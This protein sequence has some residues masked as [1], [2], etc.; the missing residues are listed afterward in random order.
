MLPFRKSTREF[1]FFVGNFEQPLPL[2]QN[3]DRR[4]TLGKRASEDLQ[5]FIFRRRIFLGKTFCKPFSESMIFSKK[6]AFWR[7]YEF[8]IRV[9]RCA[10]KSYCPNCPYFWGD[11]L[12]EGVK[13]V[14]RVFWLGFWTKHD[15]NYVV[16]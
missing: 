8:L 13:V 7:S 12:G 9:G 1:R 16:L 5:L 3:S 6:V 11:F 10:L 15:F 2:K 14:N 4:E